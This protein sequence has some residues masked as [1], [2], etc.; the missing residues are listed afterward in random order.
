MDITLDQIAALSPAEQDSLQRYIRKSLLPL[1]RRR[2]A[3]RIAEEKL[4]LGI[5]TETKY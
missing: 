3:Q 4:E 5:E 1:Q 2:L